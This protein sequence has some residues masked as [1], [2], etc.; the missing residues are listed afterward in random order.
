MKEIIILN[1]AHT[2]TMFTNSFTPKFRESNPPTGVCLG[3]GIN[4]EIRIS[5]D[6]GCRYYTEFM[7][8]N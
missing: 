3:D 1:T 8:Q 5:T 7:V 4:P 6:L 2:H